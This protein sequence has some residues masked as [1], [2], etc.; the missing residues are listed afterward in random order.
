[1]H[2]IFRNFLS[3][4][5]ASLIGQLMTFLVTAYYANIIG[6]SKFGEITLAQNIWLYFSMVVL[7]GISTYGTR[8]VTS[9]KREVK[10]YMRGA[11][12]F[13]ILLSILC[14]VCII[15]VALLS[16]K[17][18]SFKTVLIIFGLSLFPTAL[19]IDWIYNGLEEMQHNAVYVI[20]KN[21]VPCVIIY[22]FFRGNY[23][24]NLI[25]AAFLIGLICA[26]LYHLMML[27]IREGI[28]FKPTFDKKELHGYFNGGL[29]FLISGLLA[30]ING[31]ADKVIMG[32]SIDTSELGIYMAAYTF[33]NF[34]ISFS[35]LIFTPFFPSMI[36]AFNDKEMEKLKGLTTS[37]SK[38]IIM[39]VLPITFGGIILSKDI[40]MFF[41]KRQEYARGYI[42]FCIL[43]IYI[44]TLYLREIFAY[45]MNAFRMEKKYMKIVFFSASANLILNIILIPHYGMIAAAAVTFLTEFINFYFMRYYAFRVLQ[46]PILAN[47]AKAFVPTVIMSLWVVTLKYFNINILINISSAVVIYFVML[48]I[49]KLLDRDKITALILKRS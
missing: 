40:I 43:L 39:L 48:M 20:L 31:N 30:M 2:K 3:T 13:R 5:F 6:T 22:I 11:L 19:N 16:G 18:N 10:K 15:L 17:D 9:N 49:F 12:S 44:F 34:L 23:S 14:F 32:F 46:T 47:I 35:S 36:K 29:P 1:M 28:A 8:L 7:F 37:L 33:I 4:G 41:F 27:Y 25:P 38:I 21:I 26:A 45:Q 24:L 42:P